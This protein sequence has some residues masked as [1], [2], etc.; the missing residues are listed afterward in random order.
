MDN[1]TPSLVTIE[2][3][4]YDRGY[5]YGRQCADA[6]QY[7]AR[8]AFPELLKA[9]TADRL[10]YLKDEAER[11]E[12]FIVEHAS[13]L[14]EELRGVADGARIGWR[15]VL[16]LQ[17]RPELSNVRHSRLKREDHE[18][19][20]IGVGG[21]RTSDGHPLLAQNI[22]MNETLK[23]LGIVLRIYPEQGPAILTWTLAGVLGQTGINSSGVGRCGNVLFSG[24]WRL[25]VP[26]SILF[27]L[28]LE[29]E[30]VDDIVDLCRQIPR[31]KSNNFMLCDRNGKVVD[32]EMTVDSQRVIELDENS[33]IH[34]TNHYCHPEFQEED[35][36]P[37]RGGTRVRQ[38]RLEELTADI[39]G[40]IDVDD[41][42]RFMSDHHNE[43]LSLCRHGQDGGRTLASCVLVPNRSEAYISLGNPCGA[44]YQRYQL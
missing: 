32:L 3:S 4:P 39:N 29:Q 8:V 27:R 35:T 30:S 16:L 5:Q 6:I 36:E 34:H 11:Y 37:N 1:S 19:S 2:G 25:G 14:I 9:N 22:D 26:T 41:I 43:P 17:T 40:I 23:D 24:R 33:L 7:A 10:E 38:A 15:E 31:A 12:P 28:A 44:P 20:S 13:H 18:C 21:A 42:K